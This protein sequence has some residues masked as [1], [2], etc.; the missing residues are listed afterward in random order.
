MDSSP[1]PPLLF[2]FRKSQFYWLGDHDSDMRIVVELLHSL[3]VKNLVVINQF[4][5]VRSLKH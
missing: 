3:F 5:V 4:P 2:Y 1:L